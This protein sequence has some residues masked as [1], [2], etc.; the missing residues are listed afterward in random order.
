M[1]VVSDKLMKM[2]S[3]QELE[4]RILGIKIMV[5]MIETFDDYRVANSKIITARQLFYI[6]QDRL[7]RRV[8]FYWDGLAEIW[9]EEAVKWPDP[10]R[11]TPP[12]QTR[13]EI[14][15]ESKKINGDE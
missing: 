12:P 4:M 7:A 1:I 3:A 9:E 14:I 2:L 11:V 15:K 6:E 10:I 13:S 8:I 5:S